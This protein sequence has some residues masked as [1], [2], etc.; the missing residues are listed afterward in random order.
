MHVALAG[1]L[2]GSPC[3]VTTGSN[4]QRIQFIWVKIAIV[5]WYNEKYNM[6]DGYEEHAEA[7][8]CKR[9]G[10]NHIKDYV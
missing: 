5:N 10:A 4:M 9:R 3:L 6:T 7:A 2:R 1:L 8:R